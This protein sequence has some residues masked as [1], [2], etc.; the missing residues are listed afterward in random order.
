MTRRSLR[1]NTPNKMDDEFCKRYLRNGDVDVQPEWFTF[2]KA[3]RTELDKMVTLES[4]HYLPVSLILTGISKYVHDQVCASGLLCRR[5]PKDV[6]N[7]LLVYQI[8]Q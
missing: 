2:L 3:Q 6:T 8:I 4:S 1:E 5:L 7:S